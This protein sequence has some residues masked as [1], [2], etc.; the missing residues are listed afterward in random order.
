MIVETK[1]ELKQKVKIKPFS[2]IEGRILGFYYG[3]LGL[4]YYV[5]YPVEFQIKEE[6]FYEEELE[7]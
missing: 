2:F 1:F 4:K 6:Y 3:A 5:S 7:N